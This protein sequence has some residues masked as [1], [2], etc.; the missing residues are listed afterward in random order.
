ML[1]VSRVLQGI[2]IQLIAGS[3]W[4]FTTVAA[5]EGINQI[6]TGKLESL[7][8]QELMDCD[9]TFDHGCGGGL[10]DFAFAYIMGNQGIHTDEDYPYLMEEG[11]CKGKQVGTWNKFFRGNSFM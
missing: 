7:S 5:V 8:E 1:K 2:L 4:A 11:Y 6:V 9:S 3:C 10:M